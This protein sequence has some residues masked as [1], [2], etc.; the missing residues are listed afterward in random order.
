MATPRALVVDTLPGKDAALGTLDT[1]V[2]SAVLGPWGPHRGD[3]A[4]CHVQSAVIV[5]SFAE[6][7]EI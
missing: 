1:A 2:P 3:G 6:W 7:E 5:G 4:D